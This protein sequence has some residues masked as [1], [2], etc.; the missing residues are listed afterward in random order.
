[1]L[2]SFTAGLFVLALATC[3]PATSIRTDAS[4]NTTVKTVDCAT[5]TP[6]LTVMTAGLAYDPTPSMIKTGQTVM[7]V[8]APQHNVSS[9]T[10][11]LAVDFGGTRCLSFPTAG[12]YAFHCSAHSFVGT[13]VVSDP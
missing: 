4:V 12:T 9:T 3:D 5:A 13:V 6:T 10:S 7:F 8:M 1:M 11:G 2:Y